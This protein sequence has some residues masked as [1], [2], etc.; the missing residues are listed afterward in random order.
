[1]QYL[2]IPEIENIAKS[3]EE[4]IYIHNPIIKRIL[5]EYVYVCIHMC[6]YRYIHRMKI[7]KGIHFSDYHLVYSEKLSG[8]LIHGLYLDNQLEEISLYIGWINSL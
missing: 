1:M 3:N 8:E 7:T 2:F 5:Y 6:I 4:K